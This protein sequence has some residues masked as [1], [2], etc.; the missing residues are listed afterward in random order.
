MAFICKN[1]A[2]VPIVLQRRV[3]NLS[4]LVV[5]KCWMEIVCAL[6]KI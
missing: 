6:E 4:L 2:D 1:I 5:S 3:F